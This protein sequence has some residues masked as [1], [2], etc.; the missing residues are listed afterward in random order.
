MDR[1]LVYVCVCGGVKTVHV[2]GLASHRGMSTKS[3]VGHTSNF[4][5]GL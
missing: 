5:D 3:P 2:T 1:A 4:P